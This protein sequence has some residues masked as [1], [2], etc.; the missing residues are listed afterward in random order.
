MARPIIP[1][2]YRSGDSRERSLSTHSGPSSWFTIRRS[3][4]LPLQTSHGSRAHRCQRD[5]RLTE[6]PPFDAADL[7]DE[8]GYL[9]LYPGVA[10]AMMRGMVDTAWNHYL[11]HGRAEGRQPNDVDPAF[12]VAAYPEMARDLGRP[13][14]EADA[15]PHFITLGR[16]RGYLPNAAAPRAGNGAAMASPFGGLWI[17]HANALD[18]IQAR[19]DL[20]WLRRREAA[21]L[22]TFALEGFVELDR[23]NDAERVANAGVMV[24]Q[25]FTGRF[26]DLRFDGPEPRA[27]PRPWQPELTA[28]PVGACDPHMVSRAIRDLVLDKSVTDFLTLLFEARPRLTASRAFLRQAA[29]P[30]RDVAWL[31]H[32]LPLRFVAVTFTLEDGSPEGTPE[33]LAGGAALIW[34]GSHRLPDL[35]WA[36]EHLTLAEARRAGA[37]GLKAGGLEAAMAQREAAIQGLLHGQQPRRIHSWAGSRTIRHANLV[38][39]TTAPEPPLQRRTVTAWYC[40]F[41]VAPNYQEAVHARTHQHGDFEYSSGVYPALD[42]RD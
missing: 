36:G 18:L 34:S 9:R 22:R 37:P 24:A 26:P 25:A 2:R 28:Q 17:D 8:A 5:H 14:A 23:P 42:P 7:F 32:T 39:A 11:H 33:D 1:S 41:H 35:P 12:Y 21:T 13:P 10:Q 40:P 19:V 15:A 4:S 30:E 20:G 6:L 16:A 31:G 29:A 27:E 3:G 38:H